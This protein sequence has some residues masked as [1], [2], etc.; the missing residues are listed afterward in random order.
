M[1]ATTLDLE[2][3]VS[4]RLDAERSAWLEQHCES[5]D[6]CAR[7][8]AGEARLEVALRSVAA[9]LR[10][11][12]RADGAVAPV[13]AAPPVVKTRFYAMAAAACMA[14]AFFAARLPRLPV[15]QPAVLV[16]DAGDLAKAAGQSPSWAD[17]E[18]SGGTP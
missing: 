4:A 13:E 16:A 15:Q 11:G 5:C 18:L 12:M 14:L 3:F 1:H 6:S 2:M 17:R 8:V 7:A 10:C 9:E